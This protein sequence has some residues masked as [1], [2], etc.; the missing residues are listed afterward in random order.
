MPKCPFCAHP[1]AYH[2]FSAVACRNRACASYNYDHAQTCPVCDGKPGCPGFIE[3]VGALSGY[4]HK[5][6]AVSLDERLRNAADGEM[7]AVDA[8][9]QFLDDH[10]YERIC[11]RLLQSPSSSRGSGRQSWA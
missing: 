1:G 2:G 3:D 6:E 10:W 8:Q 11:A 5:A 7:I 9:S 4:S